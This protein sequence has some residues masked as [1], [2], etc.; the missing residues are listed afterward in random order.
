M[1][2]LKVDP[3]EQRVQFVL[4][5][6]QKIESMAALCRQFGISRKTGYKWR[7]RF[8]THGLPG[9]RDRPRRPHH[10]PRQTSAVWVQRIVQ[11][12]SQYPHWGSKK[13][14]V[15]LQRRTG[16]SPAV[17]ARS[18]IW[19]IVRRQGLSQPAKRRRGRTVL[20]G[21]SLRKARRANAVWAVDF[22]GRFRTRD[23]RWCEPLTV[24]DVASRYVLAVQALLTQRVEPTQRA[25]AKLFA[26]RGLPECIRCDNGGPF[27]ST[28]A[29]GLSRLSAWWQQLGIQVQWITPGHPE[30]NAVHERMHRTLKQETTRPPAPTRRAQQRRFDQWRHQFNQVRPHEAL[31]MH[32]PAQHYQ[33][34]PRRYPKRLP[35]VSY[36]TAYA[37]RRVRSNGQIKWCGRKHF[38]GQALVGMSVGIKSVSVGRHE[39]YFGLVLLGELRDN[40]SRG[41]H[42]VITRPRA[43]GATGSSPLGGRKEPTKKV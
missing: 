40:G 27:A 39:V 28:G 33:R 14:R 38:L 24:S 30:Q 22:K 16:P 10:C 23:G 4:K 18:T 21:V 26:R 37:R 1:A 9:L 32:V 2:W 25:F 43:N 19:R 8:G 31:R 15:L 29:G 3:M 12:R 34:S 35:A 36:P 11:L 13:L 6:K 5:A 17:P 42:A 7:Q 41:V 20:V